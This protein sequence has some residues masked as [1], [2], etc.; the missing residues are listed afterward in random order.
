[1]RIKVQVF[2]DVMLWQLLDPNDRSTGALHITSNYLPVEI[3]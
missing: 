3:A 1:V 2:W